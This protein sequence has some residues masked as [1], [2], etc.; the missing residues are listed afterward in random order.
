M[1]KAFLRFLSFFPLTW[2]HCLGAVLGRWVYRFDKR[3]RTRLQTNATYAGY[4][5]EEFWQSAAAHMGRGVIELAHIWTPR[6]DALLPL[7]QVKG[8]DA[9]MQAKAQGRG[10]LML[11]PH[12]GA[13]E[14]L[15]L[16]IGQREPFTAMYRPPKYAV[17]G[18]MMLSGRQKFNV[19]MASADVKGI[20]VMLRALKNKE[21]VGLLPDQVPNESADGVVVPVF[22]QPALSMTLPAKLVRQTNAALVT[23]F[24]RRVE[25]AHRFEIE[26]KVVEFTVSGDAQEDASRIN[27]L[28]EEVIRQT[29]EQYLW[30][31]NRYKRL[32]T[33][34]GVDTAGETNGV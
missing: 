27:A 18:Q 23:M 3:Y 19:N 1:A 32:P 14:L 5:G 28:M 21:L 25:A 9:V 16:W 24:A 8:W 12:V 13:F 30:A 11:T 6:V 15:S 2:L 4:E 31:Y 26:F 34:T 22:G 29:P 10:V 20:R 33:P 7:V 17:L